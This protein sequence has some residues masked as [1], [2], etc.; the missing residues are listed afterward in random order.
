MRQK[1]HTGKCFA[2]NFVESEGHE[3]ESSVGWI[4]G[5]NLVNPICY[6]WRNSRPG[7]KL[8]RRNLFTGTG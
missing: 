3:T 4:G 8:L 1:V 7:W 2:G 5:K 6:L